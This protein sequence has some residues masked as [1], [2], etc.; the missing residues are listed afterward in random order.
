MNLKKKTT[1]RNGMVGASIPA[2][3]PAPP[4]EEEKLSSTEAKEYDYR[5]HELR[6]IREQRDKIPYVIRDYFAMKDDRAS[7]QLSYLREVEL[8]LVATLGEVRAR[9]SWIKEQ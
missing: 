5:D 6:I 8:T 3:I 2:P 9:I 1:R 7:L 4:M